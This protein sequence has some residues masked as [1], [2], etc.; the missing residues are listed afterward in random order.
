VTRSLRTPETAEAPDATRVEALTSRLVFSLL[1]A[2]VR[3]AAR[4]QLPLDRLTEL[5]R[6]AY[7]VEYRRRHPRDLAA[8]ADKLGVSLRTAGTL[9]RSMNDA[10]FAPETRVEPIRRVTGALLGAPRTPEALGRLTGLDAPEVDRVLTH[11]AEVGWVEPSGDAFALSGTFRSHLAEDLGA[12]VDAIN[13]QMSVVAD[14]VHQR[15]LLGGSL[16]A[17]ARTWSFAARPEDVG[18]MIDRVFAALRH[19]AVALEQEALQDPQPA[20]F[21]LT[22]AIAA[23]PPEER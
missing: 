8:I 4:V 11:L 6:T 13:H 15:F 3:L 2:A 23:Q 14:S 5:L 7:F 16:G 10:F 20:R 12:R 21:G 19:E 18:P 9:N 17:G 22:V 1:H